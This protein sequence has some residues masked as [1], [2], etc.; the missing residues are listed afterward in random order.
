[1]GAA[2]IV[3]IGTT[4]LSLSTSLFAAVNGALVLVWIGLA[5]QIGREYRDL[6][7]SGR[8]P[9]SSAVYDEPVPAPAPAT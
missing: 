5:W 9:A 7:L 4:L 8:P 2:G 3:F 1:V 6:S